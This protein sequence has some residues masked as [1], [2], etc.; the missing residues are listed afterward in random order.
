MSTQMK[1]VYNQFTLQFTEG[2]SYPAPRP[3]EKMQ[4]TD[5]LASGKFKSAIL[6]P[7]IEA[8]VLIFQDML[9]VDH[10]A[11]K[12]WY[13]NI[14]NGTEKT[15]EFTDERGLVGNVRFTDTKFEF[16]EDDFELFSG[17]L[18]VEYQA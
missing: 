4:V 1:F 2:A 11:L 15:F 3:I 7:D 6:G 8:R 13:V 5:R 12:N 18:T 9:K 14:V 16:V 17:Q 10:D